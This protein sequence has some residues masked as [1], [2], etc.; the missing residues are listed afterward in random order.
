MGRQGKDEMAGRACS[1]ARP[2]SPLKEFISAAS[3]V[4]K[5]AQECP[6]YFK[7]IHEDLRP[8][9]E[10]GITREM[11]EKARPTANFRLVVIGGRAYVETFS[12][13]FQTRD[14]F[15]QWGILQLLRRFPGRVPDLELL[16]DC[17]DSPAIPQPLNSSA[18]Q[19]AAL[20]HY[21][22]SDSTADIV[23]PDWSF[24][25]WPE[26]NVR[27]WGQLAIEMK[28]ANQRKR[29]RD[30]EPYAFWK[31][32]PWVD[33]GRQDLLRCNVTDKKDWN[34]RLYVQ[35]WVAESKAGFKG[36]NLA[37]Q[38]THQYKIYIDGRTWSVSRKYIL[39]C[40]SPVLVVEPRYYDFFSR[41]LSPLTHFWPVRA[42]D[43]CPAIKYAVDWGRCHQ[44][45]VQEI[46]K[47]GS[48]FMFE[49]VSMDQVYNYM[50]YSL[51]EYARLLKFK[52]VVPAAAVELTRVG[53][54]SSADELSRKFMLDSEE[55]SST[56]VAS[57]C[58]LPP[59][60]KP[61][62]IKLLLAERVNTTRLVEHWEK[63]HFEE[64]T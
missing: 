53:L 64:T 37:G 35:D 29:W 10:T 23:F 15:T 8:W 13:S 20:F 33:Q 22:G 46:G 18:A 36:S 60:M 62:E 59:P 4:N 19:P 54:M 47:K 52:P 40:D 34:A 61:E 32:N 9:K 6:D 48:T 28:A 43:K 27:S 50:L 1:S 30:R 21:C 12:R 11:V 25:G 31:G 24:W 5:P 38:C 57:P 63:L 49:E 42:D 39:A 58:S 45:E 44:T 26:V 55:T 3:P 7:W 16:F 17:N 56:V 2:T 51:T 14:V 41:G